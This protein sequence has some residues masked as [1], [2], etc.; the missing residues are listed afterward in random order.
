MRAEKPAKELDQADPPELRNAWRVCA[1]IV[2]KSAGNFYY[3]FIFMPKLQRRAI[4][5]LYAFCRAGDDA[6]DDPGVNRR[7]MLENLRERLNISLSGY[8]VDDVTL[9]LADAHQRY[10]FPRQHFDDLFL[11]LESDLEVSR[12][13]SFE[14]LRLYCYRV[15]S[16]IG[17]LCLRI[18]D[19]DTEPAREYASNLG[20]GMQLTNILRD[21]RED[22]LRGR[23]YLPREDLDRFG[24]PETTM[25]APGNTQGLIELVQWQAERAEGFFRAAAANLPPDLSGKLTAAKIMGSIYR[26]ILRKIRSMD[27]F[28]SRI[29]L[30]TREKLA[31]AYRIASGGD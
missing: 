23:I 2:R 14:Q 11:G 7:A 18:F 9:A 8:Y 5:A 27:S 21:L 6:A 19:A 20:I 17:L 10:S 31:I 24:T 22:Y 15:A 12:Y 30:T 25:F 1:N 28:E 29:E 4:Q 3:A 26:A 13:E 16:T